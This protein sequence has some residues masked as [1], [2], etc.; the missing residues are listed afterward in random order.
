MNLYGTLFLTFS[1]TFCPL[2]AGSLTMGIFAYLGYPINCLML[3]T[4]FLVLAVGVDDAFLMMHHWFKSVEVD[5]S[6]RFCA[7]L[8][9]VGPSISFTSLTNICAFCIGGMLATPALQLFCYCTAVALIS[10]WILQLFV[11]AP[12]LLNFHYCSYDISLKISQKHRYSIIKYC[13]NLQKTSIRFI[14]IIFLIIYWTFGIYALLQMQ[15]DFSPKKALDT[16]SHFAKSLPVIDQSQQEMFVKFQAFSEYDIITVF[17]TKLPPDA[18]TLLNGISSIQQ[19]EYIC[20]NFNTWIEDYDLQYYSSNDTRNITLD[21]YFEHLPEFRKIYNDGYS[22]NVL[23]DQ[24]EDKKLIIKNISLKICLHG[25]ATWRQRAIAHV[26]LRKHLPPGFIIY[27]YDS[28]IFD[29]M[30]TAK[31]ITLHSCIITT[32][33]MII[34]ST[35]FIPTVQAA[36]VAALSV[37]SMNIGIVGFLSVWEVDMDIVTMVSIVMAIGLTIDYAAHICYNFFI[38]DVKLSA[39]VRMAECIDG[40]AYPIFQILD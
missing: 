32:I 31:K 1:T 16:N 6:V 18:R 24:K 5:S 36:T 39:T 15:Q 30:I 29:V 21:K 3:M 4:P 11:F 25:L 14:F 19:L 22:R 20:D 40:I 7:V 12:T 38:S 2:L 26:D 28:T 9:H 13:E 23:Y 37:L 27:T 10:D 17:I 35:V 8:I 34:L 33:C